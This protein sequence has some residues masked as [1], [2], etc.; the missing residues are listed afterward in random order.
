[1][2]RSGGSETSLKGGWFPWGIVRTHFYMSVH[3]FLHCTLPRLLILSVWIHHLIDIS[4][5][6]AFQSYKSCCTELPHG[7]WLLKGPGLPA[8]PMLGNHTGCE[9]ISVTA[10]VQLVTPCRVCLMHG[11]V[12]C[13]VCPDSVHSTCRECWFLLEGVTFLL[14]ASWNFSWKHH[15]PY[16]ALHSQRLLREHINAGPPTSG[17]T[18]V[19]LTASI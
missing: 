12:W 7:S 8:V 6:W 3:Q 13:R 18:V 19:R 9:N 14:P 11:S 17:M 15:K 4:V 1:M 5:Y 2:N 10:N 16:L